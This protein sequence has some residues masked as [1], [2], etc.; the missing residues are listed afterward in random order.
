MSCGLGR[1]LGSDLVAV[2]MAWPG[3][4]SSNLAPSM[5]AWEFPYASSVA[6]KRPKKKKSVSSEGFDQPKR[7]DLQILTDLA[8]NC[9][10]RPS[11]NDTHG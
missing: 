11:Y 7:K 3:S 2:A 4:Y 9:L 5:G 8:K 6:L 1:R 10:T